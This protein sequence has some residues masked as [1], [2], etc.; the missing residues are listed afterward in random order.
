MSRENHVFVRIGH[1]VSRF[2][3][4]PLPNAVRRIGTGKGEYSRASM[5]RT[6]LGP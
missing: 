4:I 2:V 1:T 5:A 3:T 6:P